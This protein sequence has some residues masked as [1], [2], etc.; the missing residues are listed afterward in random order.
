M[1]IL[2][3]IIRFLTEDP[4][5][6]GLSLLVA[7]IIW[8]Y[9]VLEKP[10]LVEQE[11]SIRFYNLAKEYTIAKVSATKGRIKIFAKGRDLLRLHFHPPYIDVDLSKAKKGARDF[12]LT[13][14]N[15]RLSSNAEIREISPHKVHISLKE[16]EEKRVS[17]DIPQKG[18]P[19]QG[20]SVLKITQRDTVYIWGL[21]DEIELISTLSTEPLLLEGLSGNRE[22]TLRVIPPHGLNLTCRPGSVR[23]YVE[24]EKEMEK[25]FPKIPIIIVAE[26]GIKVKVNPGEV[27]IRVKGPKSKVKKI[28]P[29][30]IE[31]IL[32]ASGLKRGKYDL[33]AEIRLPSGIN[34]V[35]CEPTRFSVIVE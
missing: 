9:S 18:S 33:L 24:I 23:V 30:D 29:K 2:R 32:D 4:V 31:V 17:L 25:T 22:E 28:E 11:V 14:K 8:F 6:K 5:L 7:I 12:I 16:L 13:S 35:K 10:Y 3:L 19:K 1:K 15:V 20:F 34:L 26:E 21:K 27:T